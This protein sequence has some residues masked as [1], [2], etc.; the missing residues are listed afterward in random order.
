MNKPLTATDRAEL[1][2]ML[3]KQARAWLTREQPFSPQI[4]MTAAAKRF[5]YDVTLEVTG[6]ANEPV[7]HF[8]SVP[9]LTS[10]KIFLMLTAGELP[11]DEI[12]FSTEQ[13][14]QRFAIFAGSQFLTSLG[15][16]GGGDRLTI[17]SGEE[18]S[19]SGSTTYDVEYKLTDRWSLVGQ[20][21]RFNEFNVS[22]K[23]RIFSR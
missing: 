12:I 2:R 11:R 17:R 7:L 20:Y 18:I 10:E 21:D 23:R 22:V 3:V 15:F 9:S 8:S 16:G 4:Y 1:E 13:K 5:G 6:T 19:E 14:A